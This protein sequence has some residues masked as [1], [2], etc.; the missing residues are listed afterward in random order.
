MLD[1]L[2]FARQR[3]L[4][5]YL[6]MCRFVVAFTTALRGGG[7][8]VIKFRS[9]STSAWRPGYP[10]P[11]HLDRGAAA[12]RLRVLDAVACTQVRAALPTGAR[13]WR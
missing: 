4:L 11:S 9:S 12:V 6:Q 5:K 13:S 10:G 7:V 3:P 8:N 2:V 1:G